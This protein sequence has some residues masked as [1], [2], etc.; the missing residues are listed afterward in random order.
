[1]TEDNSNLVKH[2]WSEFKVLG[3][4]DENNKF[5]D[6]M[7]EMICNDI[8]SLLKVFSSQGHSGHTAPYCLNIF[9]KLA[10]FEPIGPLTGEDWEWNEVGEG[11]FQN[12]RCSHVFKDKTRFNGQ[13]YDMD[14]I[15]FYDWATDENGEKFKSHF[16][17][18]ESAVPIE[19]PYTPKREYKERVS[20]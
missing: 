19:F 3:W 18:K 15:I 1:M 8:L 12:K 11:I 9:S 13:A 16:T 5:D 2:A 20:E 4:V 14:G 10:K 7:Q 17:C 6:E